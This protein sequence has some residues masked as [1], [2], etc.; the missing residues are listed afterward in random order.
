MDRP[1]YSTIARKLQAAQP[2]LSGYAH[3]TVA[4]KLPAAGHGAPVRLRER[5]GFMKNTNGIK[6]RSQKGN[7]H[8]FFGG[9]LGVL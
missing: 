1:P 2:K 5:S 7:V 6:D 4:E 8:I 3:V 9:L